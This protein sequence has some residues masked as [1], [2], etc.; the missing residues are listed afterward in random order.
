MQRSPLRLVE[1]SGTPL[2]GWDL[3]AEM[4]DLLERRLPDVSEDDPYYLHFRNLHLLLGGL[5]LDSQHRP[6]SG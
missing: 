2:A 6:R 5:N 4:I 1:G 3:R